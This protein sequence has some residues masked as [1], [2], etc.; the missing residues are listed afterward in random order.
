[1]RGETDTTKEM[2][3]ESEAIILIGLQATG[4]SEFYKR[5]FADTHVR[6]NLDMLKTRNRE[7]I[8]VDA[9]IAAKQSFVVDNTNPA[10]TDRARYIDKAKESGF[11]IIGYYFRSSLSEASSRNA[12]RPIKHQVPRPAIAGTHAKLDLPSL[13]EGF[14]EL[15]YVYIGD[16]EDFMTE[17]YKDE[18]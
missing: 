17:V 4:K 8:L 14:D 13:E 7:R 9:C 3:T 2:K 6:I 16:N 10:K 15:Y 1:M 12:A 5:N 11:R 18:I